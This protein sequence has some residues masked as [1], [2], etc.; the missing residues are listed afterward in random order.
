M[1]AVAQ[2]DRI[3]GAERHL[4]VLKNDDQFSV[5]HRDHVKGGVGV[6]VRLCRLAA[7]RRWYGED[8]NDGS[9][10]WCCRSKRPL[11]LRPIIGPSGDTPLL[12]Q[13]LQQIPLGRRVQGR[14]RSSATT[15][16]AEV[17]LRPTI[18]RRAKGG[19]SRFSR[20]IR[21]SCLCGTSRWACGPMRSGAKEDGRSLVQQPERQ[22]M[23]LT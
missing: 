11:W 13:L 19:R 6:Q 22:R 16:E 8:P 9:R 10:G 21:F 17:A 15:V 5:E 14:S 12:P 4:A 23:T 2:H 3:P 18:T 7:V 1:H 20:C